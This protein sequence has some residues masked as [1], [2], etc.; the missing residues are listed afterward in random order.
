MVSVDSVPLRLYP[1]LPEVSSSPLRRHVHVRG[2]EPLARH[3]SDTGKLALTTVSG[4]DWVMVGGTVWGCMCVSVCVCEKGEGWKRW[5]HT[6]TCLHCVAGA[7]GHVYNVETQLCQN[8]C[9]YTSSGNIYVGCKT[10]CIQS[11]QECY[12]IVTV[13]LVLH[14]HA[15]EHVMWHHRKE[16]PLGHLCHTQLGGGGSVPG[17]TVPAHG[18]SWLEFS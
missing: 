17:C 2:R 14:K 12:Y 3:V 6:L 11:V 7:S 18:S 8:S 1:T 15:L 9:V 13:H 10:C 5:V 16:T 4:N